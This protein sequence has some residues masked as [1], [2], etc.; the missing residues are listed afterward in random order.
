MSAKKLAAIV[1]LSVVIVIALIFAV[2]GSGLVRGEAKPPAWVL[3]QSVE[4]VDMNS[5]ELLTKPLI[6]WRKLGQKNGA[7]R[8]PSTRE[9]TM[10]FP[11]LCAACRKKIPTPPPPAKV[12]SSKDPGARIA[13]EQTMTCPKCGKCPFDAPR[14]MPIQAAK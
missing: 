12:L 10:A 3:E 8:N 2:R 4:L 11:M 1:L 7:Y 14:G 9:Y 5:G 6:E 13:W